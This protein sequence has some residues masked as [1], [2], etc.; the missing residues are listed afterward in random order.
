MAKAEDMVELL[1]R[2]AGDNYVIGVTE[3]LGVTEDFWEDKDESGLGELTSV[4]V[5][6][7]QWLADD[8]LTLN[9]D[10]YEA[11]EKLIMCG[12]IKKPKGKKKK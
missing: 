9:Y 11:Y 1:V 3:D 5:K 2:V 6:A 8:L 4:P 12:A 10:G 7:P